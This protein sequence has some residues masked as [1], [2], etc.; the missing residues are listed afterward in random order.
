MHGASDTRCCCFGCKKGRM[1][2]KLRNRCVLPMIVLVHTE[3]KASRECWTLFGWEGGGGKCAGVYLCEPTSRE[4]GGYSLSAETEVKGRRKGNGP[5]VLG[6][7]EQDRRLRSWHCRVALDYGRSRATSA[8]G[9]RR[10]GEVAFLAESCRWLCR[11]STAVTVLVSA[12]RIPCWR[13]T[14]GVT[15]TLPLSQPHLS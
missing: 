9:R 1:K 14:R 4:L 7:Q 12:F 5:V 3:L 15:A 8:A 6:G 11:P 10:G 13:P 2:E